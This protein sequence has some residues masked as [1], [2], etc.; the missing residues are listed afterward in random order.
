[1]KYKVLHVQIAPRADKK[2]Y[3][4]VSEGD[5]YGTD[6]EERATKDQV[7]NFILEKMKELE[8]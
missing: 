1:M 5:I 3:W 7:I 4:F 2:G 8:K 6:E